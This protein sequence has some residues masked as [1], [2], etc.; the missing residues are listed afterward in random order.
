MD[1]TPEP[2]P[3]RTVSA[4]VAAAFVPPLLA[5]GAREAERTEAAVVAVRLLHA[6]S[7]V[8]ARPVCAR[9]GAD[10]A[11]LPV[12]ALRTGAG[13]VVHLILGGGGG[14]GQPGEKRQPRADALPP[15]D[16][17]RAAAAIS[18]GVA[19]AFVGLDLAVFPGEAGPAGA[20]VAALAGVG[21]RGL[22]LTRPVIGAIVQV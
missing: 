4:G 11:V 19:V 16:A 22:V 13:V 15:A 6:G 12:E 8:K 20:G 21:A 14:G 1:I 5:V 3:G 9:H 2:W 18:A 10:L 7:A 17:H